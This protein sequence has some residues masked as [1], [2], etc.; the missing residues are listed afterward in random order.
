VLTVHRVF[1]SQL[2]SSH[3]TRRLSVSMPEITHAEFLYQ[4][5]VINHPGLI[6]QS[7]RRE[8]TR[9]TKE[10]SDSP[11]MERSHF[12]LTDIKHNHPAFSC[13]LALYTKTTNQCLGTKSERQV[14]ATI[15]RHALDARMQ[16]R[17]WST[18]E[19]EE[20]KQLCSCVG[21]RLSA[22]PLWLRQTL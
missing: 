10:A 2:Y 18:Q 14:A 12:I 19:A 1:C 11:C 16:R 6:G 5:V 13:Y 22:M 3:R 7:K 21:S 17:L 8:E 20:A 4:S 9:I 15:C